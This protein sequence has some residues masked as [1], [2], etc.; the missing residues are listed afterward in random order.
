MKK[1]EAIIRH[2]MLQAVQDVIDEMGISGITV[3]EVKGCGTQRGYTETYRGTPVHISLRPRIKVESVVPEE[4]AMALAEAIARAA[5]TG[6][7]GDGKVF[8]LP[9]EEAIRIR[10]LERGPDVVRHSAP[11]KWGH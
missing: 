5:S 7:V 4:I 3:S 1:I 8:I 9:V 11:E 6:S 2:E 10:S